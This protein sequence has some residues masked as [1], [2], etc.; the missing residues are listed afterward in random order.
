MRGLQENQQMQNTLKARILNGSATIIVAGLV[1]IR[2]NPRAETGDA[3]AIA[4]EILGTTRHILSTIGG[5]LP[6]LLI[7]GGDFWPS[8]AIV[9]AGGVAGSMIL[10]LVF[11]PAVYVLMH[12]SNKKPLT[13]AA[14]M[15]DLVVAG[16][17][18]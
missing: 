16:Q 4:E 11:V 10:A 5:F 15:N 6:L 12:G 7:V 9:L 13:E 14:A 8:L 2:A 1:A 17:P 3:I 18:A